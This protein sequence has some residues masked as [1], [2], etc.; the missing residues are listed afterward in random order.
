MNELHFLQRMFE[1]Y[2]T[3]YRRNM[4]HTTSGYSDMT[5]GELAFFETLGVHL[6]YTVRRE[7]N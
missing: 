1:G 5:A 2:V 7:M 6:G 4:W 3:T